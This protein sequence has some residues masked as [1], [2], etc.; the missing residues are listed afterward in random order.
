[1]PIRP[2]ARPAG[3]G[4]KRKDE[5]KPQ[6]TSEPHALSEGPR[7]ALN[8]SRPGGV[9]YKLY[10]RDIAQPSKGYNIPAR[11]SPVRPSIIARHSAARF[12]GRGTARACNATEE[13]STATTHADE[14]L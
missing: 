9:E 4:E 7:A 2:F 12:T 6:E 10:I 11:P 13:R 5:P 1:M 14:E 3:N 8:W